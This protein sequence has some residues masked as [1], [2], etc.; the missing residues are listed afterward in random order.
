MKKFTIIII[1]SYGLWLYGNSEIF[2]YGMNHSLFEH[3]HIKDKQTY[4]EKYKTSMDITAAAGIKWWRPQGTFR[5]CDVQPDSS[6]QYYWDFETEDSLVKWSKE[7]GL[8]LLPSIGYT[9]DWAVDP[10]TSPLNPEDRRRYPPKSDYWSD[11][12][13]Y[14]DTLVKRYKNYIKYWQFSNEPHNQYFLGTPGQYVEMYNHT[15]TALKN[16]APSAKIVGLCLDSK[17]SNKDYKWKYFNPDSGK[18]ITMEYCDN[19]KI[20]VRSLLIDSIGLDSIDVVSHH[21]YYYRIDSIMK[22]L[23]TLRNIVGEDKPIWITEIGFLHADQVKGERGRNENCGL[24]LATYFSDSG[25]IFQDTVFWQKRTDECEAI[26]DTLINIEDSVILINKADDN[27]ADTIVYT[28]GN[29]IYRED[30]PNLMDTALA[31]GDTLTIFHIWAETR[32]PQHCP[33]TQAYRYS[34]LLEHFHCD[35]NRLNNL[36]IF[37]FCA[38]N[39]IHRT[40]YPPIIRFG[41]QPV[42]YL[43]QRIHEVYS[44]IDTND[45][46]YPAYYTIQNHIL[47]A[48][49]NLQNITVGIDTTKTYQA[50]NSITAA[51]VLGSFEIKNGGT[52]AMEAGDKVNLKPGFKVKEGGYFYAATN[53]LYGEG[54]G[55]SSYMRKSISIPKKTKE[56]KTSEDKDKKGIPKVFSCDQNYP[57]PFTLRTTIKYGLPKKSNVS[58]EIFNLVGQKVR[59]LVDAKQSAGYKSVSWDG[60]TN[61]GKQVPQGVYFYVLKAGDKFEKKFKMILLK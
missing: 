28:G 40:Y 60:R 35:S 43:K 25:E 3:L 8:N 21:F 13:G 1:L 27:K 37:S 42:E 5:W 45:D 55:T 19:W 12:E 59:K 52:V 2:P 30:N 48:T 38:G 11:Y 36:K 29:L 9:A 18:I 32:I 7:R 44:V 46:P 23:D 22:W 20:A 47:P 61:A 54:G 10:I 51:G 4:M 41:Y 15:R 34:K 53:P 50:M 39:N 57:N 33:D 56:K 31:I 6:N 17:P 24:S 14:V 49:R 58:I 16:A 26:T